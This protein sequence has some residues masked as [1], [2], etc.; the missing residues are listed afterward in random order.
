MRFQFFL[1]RLVEQQTLW[2]VLFTVSLIFITWLGFTSEPYPVPSSPS[3]KLNHLLA[4][5]ELTLLARLGWPLIGVAIPFAVLASFGLALEI[6]QAYTPWRTFSL[7]DLAADIVGIG[8]GFAL[9]AALNRS[10]LRS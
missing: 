2:R 8:V 3:D 6:G 7:F 1:T 9:A 4:F 10:A 5:T